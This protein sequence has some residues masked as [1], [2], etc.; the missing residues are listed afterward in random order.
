MR[1]NGYMQATLTQ[2]E[3]RN[4]S[5]RVMREVAAGATFVVTSNGRPVAELSPLTKTWFSN[6]A[7]VLA[8]FRGAPAV[9][10][11]AFKDDIDEFVDM[12]VI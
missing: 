4:E 5:G 1:Y 10:A 8:G 2:R 11:T 6:T 3:L 9:D 7:A 12:D